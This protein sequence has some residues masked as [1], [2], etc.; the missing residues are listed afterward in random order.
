MNSQY[1][2]SKGLCLN[3]H[4][5]SFLGLFNLPAEKEKGKDEKPERREDRDR[6]RH[7]HVVEFISNFKLESSILII[8]MLIFRRRSR[9]HSRDRKHKDKHRGKDAE[10]EKRKD[11][12]K[13]KDKGKDKET[14]K[15]KDKAKD[16]SRQN[17]EEVSVTK[18]NTSSVDVFS[19]LI[20]RLSHNFRKR[21][22][23]LLF[24]SRG[25]NVFLWDTL[26]MKIL[27]P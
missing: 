1:N 17:K 25:L 13:S 7:R 8:I 12:G 10:K 20:Q 24:L 22:K 18:N 4:S 23:K 6:R 26:P 27:K 2:F 5:F 19:S 3:Q 14:D 15:E 21:R 11:S 16:K 9:S